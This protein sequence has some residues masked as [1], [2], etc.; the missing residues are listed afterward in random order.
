MTEAVVVRKRRKR[1]FTP[2]EVDEAVA[3]GVPFSA[4]YY[5]RVGKGWTHGEAIAQPSRMPARAASKAAQWRAEFQA[6]APAEGVTPRVYAR[7]REA[8]WPADRAFAVPARRPCSKD[9]GDV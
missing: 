4:Y 9:G 5:R 2:A 3:A 1:V 8:G 6:G 7:R